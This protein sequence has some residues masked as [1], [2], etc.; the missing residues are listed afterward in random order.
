MDPSVS[1]T[2]TLCGAVASVRARFCDGCGVRFDPA[3]AV[4]PL[5][6]DGE[7]QLAA[8]REEAGMLCSRCN[9]FNPDGAVYCRRCGARMRP[10]DPRLALL[11]SVLA[12]G[13]GQFYNR[14]Y[15]K[16][17]FCLVAYAIAVFLSIM[18]VVTFQVWA[19][20]HSRGAPLVFA[21]LSAAAPF[22][23]VWAWQLANTRAG[24]FAVLM[25]PFVAMDLWIWSMISAYRT[26]RQTIRAASPGP[27]NVRHAA[28]ALNDG[29]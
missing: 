9:G 11:L 4:E 14:Q 2:C 27:V 24:V 5:P 21:D 26:A 10:R 18:C 28:R 22:V 23:P 6:R 19:D 17:L 16:G 1:K 15:F 13:L 3:W 7:D 12:A 25:S 29:S 8:G 20:V